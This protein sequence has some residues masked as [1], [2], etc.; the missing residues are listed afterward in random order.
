[1]IP[2]HEY[3]MP[4]FVRGLKLLLDD[5]GR[6]VQPEPYLDVIPHTVDSAGHPAIYIGDVKLS[7]FRQKLHDCGFR[8]EFK[9]GALIVNGTVALR[10]EQSVGAGNPSIHIEG[11][12]SEDYF[13]VRELL[14]SQYHIL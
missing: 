4:K 11:A 6:L 9:G 13:K 8:A 12:L 2:P 7:N 14:Y 1:M 10:R 5:D 3:G